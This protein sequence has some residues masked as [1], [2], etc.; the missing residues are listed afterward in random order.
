MDIRRHVGQN[1]RRIRLEKRIS[2]EGLA[3]EAEVDRS[4]VS[5]LERGIKNPTVLILE[6]LA[7]VLGVSVSALT[8][9]ERARPL[10]I[11]K[12]LPR[13]RH[14]QKTRKSNK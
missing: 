8:A 14:S 12:G 1:L 9:T 7:A 11:H 2:Q 10:S 6:K 4:Y 13:G 5:G 3:L